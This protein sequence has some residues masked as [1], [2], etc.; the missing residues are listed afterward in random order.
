MPLLSEVAWPDFG[1][2]GVP[3][4]PDL[5]EYQRRLAAFRAALAARRLEIGVL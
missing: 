5:A 1:A 2:P 3:A 4:D